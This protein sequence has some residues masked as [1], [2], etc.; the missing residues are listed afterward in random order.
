MK[1]CF[2]G[3]GNIAQAIIDGLLKNGM[4][5]S[6]IA[7]IERNEQRMKSLKAQDLQI[8]ELE[9]LASLDFDLIVLAVKPKDALSAEQSIFKLAPTAIILSVVAGIG[10]EKYSQ[11]KS[12][13]RAMPNTACAFGKGITAIYALDQ[14]S[15]AFSSANSL[16]R[17]VGHVLTLQNEDEMHRF[18]S[19]IGSGQAF[20]FQVLNTY[21]KELE[22]ISSTD[23]VATKS[24]FKDFISGL[25]DSF[26]QDSNFE[27]LINKIKSP[28]GTTQAGL[29]S[30][31][32]NNLDEILK[33]AFTAAENRSIQL[34]EES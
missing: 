19:I 4:Q 6:N 2:L 32:N 29:E 1:I 31:Q 10:I 20:L 21:L 34:S 27:S 23:Q 30:L 16:F 33:D 15:V 14:D 13:I 24:M 25:G 22:K 3:C 26:S 11:P 5:P 9:N 12:I 28:G 17:K 18:T 8:I 7:C